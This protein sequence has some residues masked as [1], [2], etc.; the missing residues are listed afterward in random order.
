MHAK[1]SKSIIGGA[2]VLLVFGVLA[3]YA[4][5]AIVQINEGGCGL[6]DGDGNLVFTTDVIKRKVRT[7]SANSNLIITCHVKDI[8]N[9]TGTAVHYRG[10]DDGPCAI[11]DPLGGVRLTDDWHETVSPNGEATITCQSKL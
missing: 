6:F 9:S 2:L 4:D 11:T 10:P 3:A 5:R 1:M 7:Q 8:P